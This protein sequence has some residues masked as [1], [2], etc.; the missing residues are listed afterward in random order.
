[1]SVNQSKLASVIFPALKVMDNEAVPLKVDPAEWKSYPGG[2]LPTGLCWYHGH[3]VHGWAKVADTERAWCRRLQTLLPQEYGVNRVRR[4][5]LYPASRDTCDLVLETP[6]TFWLEVKAA[7]KPE[8]QY[9]PLSKN[10]VYRKHLI[11]PPGPTH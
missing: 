3:E 6:G 1:M 4:D 8:Y 10:K 11:H 2:V 5:A 7:W 9:V